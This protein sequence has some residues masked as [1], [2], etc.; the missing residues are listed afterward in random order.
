L[1]LTGRF[2]HWCGYRDAYQILDNYPRATFAVLDRAG[3]GLTIEQNILFRALV[4]E[5]LDRVE[6][7]ALKNA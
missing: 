6:E 7:Y 5:W 4:S 1:F 2:D 3:H